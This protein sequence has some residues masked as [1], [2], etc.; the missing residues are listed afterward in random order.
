MGKVQFKRAIVALIAAQIAVVI[1]CGDGGA[2]PRRSPIKRQG[3]GLQKGGTAQ[4]PN[5][6]NQNGITPPAPP[7]GGANGGT[8]V[9]GLPGQDETRNKS[10]L[11]KKMKSDLDLRAAGNAVQAQQLE[12]GLYSLEEVTSHFVYQDSGRGDDVEILS[13]YA[14]NSLQLAKTGGNS[15]GL[16]SNGMDSGRQIIVPYK[17]FVK[18]LNGQPWQPKRDSS[19]SEALL[20][21]FAEIKPGSMALNDSFQ[22]GAD[23]V[24]EV[25]VIETLAS[26]PGQ[27]DGEPAYEGTDYNGKKLYVRVRKSNE[28]KLRLL[29]T[30]L[31]Q[32]GAT[33]DAKNSDSKYMKR[34]LVLTFSRQALPTA[35]ND[36]MNS[37]VFE[38][39][40]SDGSSTQAQ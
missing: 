11:M 15:V 12:E 25:S 17:F 29:I 26:Q 34:T 2:K 13:T 20:K 7:N 9:A 35:N 28:G 14:N 39:K 23:V 27:I 24:R 3:T 31:E 19:V 38:Q 1:G 21:T 16:I 6:P 33:T 30:V 36:P 37:E 40:P 18:G 10:D 22:K 8:P 32:G 5:L 4:K